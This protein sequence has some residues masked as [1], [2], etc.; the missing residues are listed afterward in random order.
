M[1]ENIKTIKVT[2]PAISRPAT[3][4]ARPSVTVTADWKELMMVVGE[5]RVRVTPVLESCK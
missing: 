5:G 3:L 4:V 1:A 2:I